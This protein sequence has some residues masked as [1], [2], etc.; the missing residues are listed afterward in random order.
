MFCRDE[1][2]I[3]TWTKYHKSAVL[4]SQ[5]DKARFQWS[6]SLQDNSSHE[7][8]TFKYNMQQ[9]FILIDWFTVSA[10]VPQTASGQVSQLTKMF[11]MTTK[12]NFMSL[13]VYL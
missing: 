8:P 5:S 11:P 9:I 7:Q 13:T 1:K 3:A 4:W 2:W 10:I 12:T 6:L